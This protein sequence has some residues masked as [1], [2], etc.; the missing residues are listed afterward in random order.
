MTVSTTKLASDI[1]LSLFS[2]REKIS[3]TFRDAMGDAYSSSNP[4]KRKRRSFEKKHNAIMDIIKRRRGSSPTSVAQSGASSPPTAPSPEPSA[5]EART[6]SV[7]PAMP[8]SPPPL[9]PSHQS[10]AL[11]D[12]YKLPGQIGFARR[13]MLQFGINTPSVATSAAMHSALPLPPVRS[14]ASVM[15]PISRPVPHFAVPSAMSFQ[16]RRTS[17]QGPSYSPALMA[18][19]MNRQRLVQSAALI[20]RTSVSP[21]AI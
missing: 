4:Y 15:L 9:S 21:Q 2:A 14:R 7:P 10:P 12:L 16:A 13:S 11:M 3:Q 20:R 5:I 17:L 1:L 19:V 18:D 6:V 8:S